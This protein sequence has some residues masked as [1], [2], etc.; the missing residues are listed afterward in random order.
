MANIID[1][2]PDNAPTDG[3]SAR[4]WAEYTGLLS[5]VVIAGMIALRL[6]QTGFGALSGAYG[7]VN[8]LVEENDG[9]SVDLGDGDGL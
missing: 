2:A 3:D 4:D 5:G 6:G 8:N 7:F 9:V 1:D